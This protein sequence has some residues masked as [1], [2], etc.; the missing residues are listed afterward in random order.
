[1]NQL[2]GTWQFDGVNFARVA[3]V[4]SP[5]SGKTTLSVCLE[6]ILQRKA[7]HLDR[8]LW[9]SGWVLPP[10]EERKAIHDELIARD[11][12]LIDGM[13]G[14]LVAERYARAT[15]VIHLDYPT[16]LCLERARQRCAENLGKQRFDM[17]D[18]CEDKIDDEFVEYIT[19]FKQNV[20]EKLYELETAHPEVVLY[21]F[22]DP[23]QTDEFVDE[24]K[25][26]MISKRKN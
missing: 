15:V 21:R 1:M 24:L 10:K 19:N 23:E 22:T 13:W 14:S 17:A 5:G 3:I 8:L 18:G 7:V 20:G 2:R 16:E 12:W 4:G 25:L 6:P 9:R 11:T 26:Y